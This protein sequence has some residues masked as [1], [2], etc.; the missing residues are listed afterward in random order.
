MAEP[1]GRGSAF[2]PW[3]FLVVGL[4]SVAVGAFFAVEWLTK[5][6]V[7]VYGSCSRGSGSCLQGGETL[8]MVMTL[9]WVPV[10]LVGTVCGVAMAVRR[11]RRAAADQALLVTGL[12]G[13]A[14][15]TGVRL[16]GVTT[17]TNGRITSQGYLLTL[18]PGDGG[19]PLST[20]VTLPPGVMAGSRVR[21]AYDP[22]TR[23]VVLL[24]V[25]AAPAA[26]DLLAPA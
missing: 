15:V 21:V 24:D 5:D 6:E 18:D 20:K 25:P 17:R 7:D 23:D 11:R 9:I 26:A 1:K 10:G 14:I 3:A 4:V 8:N 22:T 12:Q 19:A 2:W 13:D 16:R